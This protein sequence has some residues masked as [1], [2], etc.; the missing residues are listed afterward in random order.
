MT[1]YL[2]GPS[3]K[4][5]LQLLY[6]HFFVYSRRSTNHSIHNPVTQLF[7]IMGIVQLAVQCVRLHLCHHKHLGNA[8]CYH[9]M[10]ATLSPGDRSFSVHSNLMGLPLVMSPSLTKASS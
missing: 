3:G 8:W 9:D 2:L 6:S 7:I 5:C 1:T 10:M 4:A